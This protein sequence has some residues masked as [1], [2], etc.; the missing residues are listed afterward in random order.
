MTH[1]HDWHIIFQT[2]RI[3]MEVCTECY[4]RKYFRIDNNGRQDLHYLKEHKRD[5]LQ[6]GEN[7]YYK[8]H[9]EKMQ[10]KQKKHE[11]IRLGL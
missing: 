3:S 4:K 9:P 1:L 8:Y 6:P 10:I 11:F 5:I 2:P 7:L